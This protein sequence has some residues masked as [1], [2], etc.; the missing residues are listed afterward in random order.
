MKTKKEIRAIA[1][2][3]RRAMSAAERA[4]AS[5]RI[6]DSILR[7]DEFASCDALYCYASYAQEVSTGRLIREC[8]SMGLMVAL[9]RVSGHDMDFYIVSGPQD[10]APGYRGIP[11]PEKWCAPANAARPLMIMPGT[12]FDPDLHR[13]GY[14]GGFYDRYL[15]RCHMKTA[16]AAFECQ[17]FDRI[18][19]EATDI[20]PDILV[21]EKR[22]IYRQEENA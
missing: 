2:K 4:A 22:I 1:L 15:A 8:M 14:G 20:R 12:A 13:L 21:T 16:A 11:E 18:P 3:A 19:N 17:I 9:P 10:I 5:D 6:T 7:L